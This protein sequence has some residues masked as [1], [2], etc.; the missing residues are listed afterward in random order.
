MQ[1]LNDRGYGMPDSGL[2]LDL[3]YN[4]SGAYLPGDQM[5]LEADFKKALKEDFEI[6]FHNSAYFHCHSFPKTMFPDTDPR[7]TPGKE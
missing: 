2:R 5:A 1:E 4:P 3:V 7:A 6:Q